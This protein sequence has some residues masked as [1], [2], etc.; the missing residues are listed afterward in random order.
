M[1]LPELTPQ[2]ALLEEAV[3]ILFCRVDDHLLSA[4]PKGTLKGEATRLSRSSRTLRS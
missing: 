2:L 1:T 4:G 3:T